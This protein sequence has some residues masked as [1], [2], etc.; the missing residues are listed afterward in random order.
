MVAAVLKE[1][2]GKIMKRCDILIARVRVR[3]RR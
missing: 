2:S 1:G 3:A